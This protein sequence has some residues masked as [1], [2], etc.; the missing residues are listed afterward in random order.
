MACLKNGKNESVN[1]ILTLIYKMWCVIWPQPTSL[2]S[3]IPF[4][5][6]LM[7]KLLLSFIL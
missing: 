7:K 3:I 5:F 2:P 6:P 1:Q 4:S